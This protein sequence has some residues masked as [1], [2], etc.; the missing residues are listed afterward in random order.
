MRPNDNEMIAIAFPFFEEKN[1]EPFLKKRK[2]LHPSTCGT[3]LHDLISF[4]TNQFDGIVLDE[5]SI[6]KITDHI[7][8]KLINIKNKKLSIKKSRIVLYLYTLCK[9][10]DIVLFN[11]SLIVTKHSDISRNDFEKTYGREPYSC[12]KQNYILDNNI[13]W[14]REL[15]LSVT[16]EVLEQTCHYKKGFVDCDFR[17]VSHFFNQENQKA[18]KAFKKSNFNA[19]INSNFTMSWVAHPII[20]RYA[21][22]EY[23]SAIKC[24]SLYDSIAFDNTSDP[25]VEHNLQNF[26]EDS[27]FTCFSTQQNICNVMTNVRTQEQR[28]LYASICL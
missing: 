1:N 2:N 25:P 21:K 10:E 5:N 19:F 26:L 12:C 17:L 14:P 23:L 8:N 6:T 3:P 18:C 22:A 16:K 13:E 28:L 4:D 15:T 24:T 27:L 20:F 7:Y 9:I 11:V